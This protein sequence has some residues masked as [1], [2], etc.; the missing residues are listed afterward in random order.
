MMKAMTMYVP[1][2]TMWNLYGSLELFF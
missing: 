1:I 2:D